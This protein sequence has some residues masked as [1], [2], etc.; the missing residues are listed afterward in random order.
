MV[1][2]GVGAEPLGHHARDERRH[3]LVQVELHVDLGIGAQRL[4]HPH[5]R[6]E[7]RHVT[8]RRRHLVL[9][10]LGEVGQEL[11]QAAVRGERRQRGSEH[12]GLGAALAAAAPHD[13]GDAVEVQLELLAELVRDDGLHDRALTALTA[14]LRLDRGRP[15]RGLDV[16]GDDGRSEQPVVLGGVDARGSIDVGRGRG[17]LGY[18]RLHALDREPVRHDVHGDGRARELRGEDVLEVEYLIL[19]DV[20]LRVAG[21]FV[22]RDGPGARGEAVERL[23][24]SHDQGGVDVVGAE[25]G[26]LAVAHELARVLDHLPQSVLDVGRQR[27]RHLVR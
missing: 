26:A 16:S 22:E 23:T 8:K 4:D 9:H 19:R 11:V 2:V 13:G 1:L 7:P 6:L 18:E 25:L 5:E 14:L 10:E 3:E 12:G 20:Q 15:G 27:A 24:P 21:N 17:I